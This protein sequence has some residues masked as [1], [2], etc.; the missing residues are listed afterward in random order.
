MKLT[1]MLAQYEVLLDK[2]DQLAQDTKDNN[3]SI[4]KLKA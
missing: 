2:K 3:A 1:E 4:D